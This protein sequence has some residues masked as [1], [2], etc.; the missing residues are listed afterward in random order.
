MSAFNVCSRIQIA[1]H[2]GRLWVFSS[3]MTNEWPSEKS[4]IQSEPENACTGVI[5]VVILIRSEQ[6]KDMLQWVF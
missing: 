3:K 1:S 6:C 2:D 5:G 4:V